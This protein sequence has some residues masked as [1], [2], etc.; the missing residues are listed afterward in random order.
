M[1]CIHCDA[2]SKYKERE[3]RK[4]PKCNHKFAMEP[5]D[6]DTLTD[7]AIK[8]VLEIAGSK[9]QVKF[10]A[11]HAYLA[12]CRRHPRWTLAWKPE[13]P[14][15]SFFLAATLGAAAAATASAEHW[16]VAA[17][18]LWLAWLFGKAGFDTVR[19]NAVGA[20]EAA[21]VDVAAPKLAQ[22][23]LTFSLF[24]EY[25]DR[26]CQV[27]GRPKNL[28][29]F[30]ENDAPKRLKGG[31]NTQLFKEVEHYSFDRAVI[32]D[33]ADLVDV[34]VANDFHFE[35]NCAILSIDGHPTAVFG[36]VRKML[37]KNPKLVVLAVH[38]ASVEGCRLAWQLR[39]DPQWFANT[40]RI[41]DVGLR[42]A[43]A[44]HFAN[45]AAALLHP[46]DVTAGDGIN[47]AEARWLGRYH[48]SAAAILPEQLVKRL[49][50]AFAQIESGKAP[51]TTGS[52][53]SDG[54]VVSLS[55]DSSGDFETADSFG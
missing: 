44:A 33:R 55:S 40:G 35:N 37:R 32:C 47:A 3:G 38:D 50:A 5:K 7:G 54:V 21:T 8:H 17:V 22:T 13:S 29:G 36:T 39:H 52:T 48:L 10:L 20:S 23:S 43:H 45:Q 2:D 6:G 1:K 15:L 12:Y 46:T 53:S 4:C 51:D 19:S 30:P 31:A 34:L 25:L 11:E 18:L 14:V 41:V 16:L 28:V 42:P 26:Y 27:H 49:H 24:R 9:G